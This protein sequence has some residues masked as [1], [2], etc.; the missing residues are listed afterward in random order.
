MPRKK[1]THSRADIKAQIALLESIGKKVTA[2]KLH[3]DGTFRV[4]TSD[5]VSSHVTAST[6]APQPNE[7]DEVLPHGQA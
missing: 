3:P 6:A 5:H 2:V 4:M 1:L 7:W